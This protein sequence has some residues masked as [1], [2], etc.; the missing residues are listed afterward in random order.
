M[1][2]RADISDRTVHR[3]RIPGGRYWSM[4]LKRGFSL[5]LIDPEG[6]GNAAMLLY[7][8]ANLLERYNMA[9][10]LKGQHTSRLTAGNMLYSDMGRVMLS[11]VADTCGWHDAIGGFSTAADV[12]R[13]Y[14]EARYQ[15]HR[16]DFYRNGRELFLVELGKWGLGRRDLVPNINFFSK[17]HADEQGALHYT[18]GNSAAGSFVDLRAEMDTLVVMQTAPHPMDPSSVYAPGPVDLA[19]FRSEPVTEEDL[20]RTFRP[21]NERAW[22]N[23]AIFNCQG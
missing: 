7:N 20:C 11:I 14:G 8:P 4:V 21:E 19:I 16:N 12:R 10:T 6:G 23:T 2:T 15:E 22:R 3:D 5:R 1:T 17:V 9:D 13:K 18:P